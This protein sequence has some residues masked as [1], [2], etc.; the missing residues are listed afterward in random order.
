MRVGTFISAAAL[1]IAV[2]ANPALAQPAGI[3]LIDSSF[4]RPVYVTGA[5]GSSSSTLLFVVEQPGVIRVLDNEVKDAVPF[6]NITSLVSFA[7]ERGLLS[8]AFHPNYETNRLFYVAFTNQA[9]DVEVAEFKRRAANPKRADPTTRRRVIVI[10]HRD[11]GNHNGGQ[12]QFGPDGFLYISIGD[13]G[14]TPEAAPNLRLLLGKILRINP[15]TGRQSLYR[16][17]RQ[18]LRRHRQSQEGNLCLRLAQSLALLL[19]C[20][21]HRHRRCRPNPAGGAQFPHCPRRQGSEFWLAAIRRQ[22]TIRQFASGSG[23]RENAAL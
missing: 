23:P 20:R 11:A 18:S 21:P 3:Q 1:F 16:S 14:A 6:L 5:P 19:R 8:V 13:G 22:A 4:N 17:T 7:G 9:G 15:A 2:T 10:P 12:L